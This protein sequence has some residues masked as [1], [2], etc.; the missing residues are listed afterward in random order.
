RLLNRGR[1]LDES[2]WLQTP[3][4]G[5]AAVALVSQNLVYLDWRSGKSAIL[6][7]ALV[8]LGWASL[9]VWRLLGRR[10]GGAPVGVFAA[11]LVVSLF[12]GMGLL[13][14]GAR[15]YAGHAWWDEWNYV[16]IAQFLQ[17]FRFHTDV[18][19]IGHHAIVANGLLLKHDRIGQ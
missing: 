14:V 16:S 11:A 15:V 13:L 1:P 6:I 2:A 5:L 7:W 3:F 19:D 9:A 17:D 10:G 12:H 18:D 4:I 8:V